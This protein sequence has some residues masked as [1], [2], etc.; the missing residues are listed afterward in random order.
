MKQFD[1]LK[2]PEEI[3]K[4]S[5]NSW[6]GS[7]NTLKAEISEFHENFGRLINQF[8]QMNKKLTTLKYISIKV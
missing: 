5:G 7:G 1:A 2:R 6:K 8:I 4:G 3:L